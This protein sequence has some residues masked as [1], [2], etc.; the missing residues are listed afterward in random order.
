MKSSIGRLSARSG[1]EMDR[2]DRGR[3]SGRGAQEK[4]EGWKVLEQ[5]GPRNTKQKCGNMCGMSAV[6]HNVHSQL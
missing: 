5:T 4:R 2:R 3:G 6:P 1:M